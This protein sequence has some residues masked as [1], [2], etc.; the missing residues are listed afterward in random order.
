LNKRGSIAFALLLVIVFVILGAAILLR[1]MQEGAAANRMSKSTCALWVSEA[2]IQQLLYEYNY[3]SCHNMVQ[4]GTSIY[5]ANCTS[6]GGVSKTLAGTLSGYGDYDVTLDNAGSIIRST[7]SVPNRTNSNKIAR[8]VQTTISRPAIFG[9]GIY[10]Q[11]QVTLVNNSLVDSYNSSNGAYGGANILTNGNV[12]TNGTTTGVITIDNNATVK[13][14]VATGSGG[15]VTEGNGVTVTGTISNNSNVSLPPVVV[16]PS[17]ISLSSSGTLSLGNNV[18]QALSGGDYKYTNTSLSNNSTLNITGNV[19]LYLTSSGATPALDTQ[20]AHVSINIASGATLA[21]YSD[22]I[23]NFGNNATIN[24]ASHTPA[25]FLIYSTYSGSN[26][27]TV[28]NNGTSYAGIYAPNTDVDVSNNNGFYGSVVGKTVTL[29]NNGEIH[30][31][32][33]LNSMANPFESAILS[34]WQEF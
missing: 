33:A 17:L 15:T 19:R 11:G 24:T 18:T 1:S 10:A 9:N 27:V 32:E 31:D 3:N 25:N 2:G 7:G 12:G 28:N 6:C 21:I 20:T 26:G 23:I 29:D 4:T 5:C 14:N 13:G 16:P 30:Y 8:N 22:G 34:N